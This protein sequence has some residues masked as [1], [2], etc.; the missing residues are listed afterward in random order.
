MLNLE[1]G[2]KALLRDEV[3][4]TTFRDF[5]KNVVRSPEVFNFWIEVELFRKLTSPEEMLEKAQSIYTQYCVEGAANEINVD[6]RSRKK[7][8]QNIES[9]N[10]DVAL[11]DAMQRSIFELL[12][13]DCFLQF[14]RTREYQYL[15][16]QNQ[17][18]PQKR[19][20]FSSNRYRSLVK[21]VTSSQDNLNT[22]ILNM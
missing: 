16:V 19:L 14:F 20:Q 22:Y 6:G 17:K 3:G 2:C 10:V 1:D 21:R 7:A 8:K 5:V 9:G 4:C 13:F 15:A 11:F 18:E 12:S